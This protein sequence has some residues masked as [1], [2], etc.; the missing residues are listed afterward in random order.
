MGFLI[1]NS[2]YLSFGRENKYKEEVGKVYEGSF[3]ITIMLIT[4]EGLF[5]FS[6]TRLTLQKIILKGENIITYQYI[7]YGEPTLS[8]LR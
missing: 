8:P 4:D 6:D 3:T 2:L 7:S 1:M 5:I